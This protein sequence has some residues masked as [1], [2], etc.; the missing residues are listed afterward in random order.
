MAS[1]IGTVISV[2]GTVVIFVIGAVVYR[3][4]PSNCDIC[5][6]AIKNKYYKWTIKGEEK[7]LCPNCNAQVNR[8]VSAAAVRSALGE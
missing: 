6:A 3:R 8:K 4:S 1:E 2:V 7:T 5:G